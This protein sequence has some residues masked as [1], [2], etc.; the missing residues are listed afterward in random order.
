MKLG[1]YSISATVEI[2]ISL[3]LTRYQFIPAIEAEPP[4]PAPGLKNGL[5]AVYEANETGGTTV[6]D[7]TGYGRN[8]TA[9][10]PITTT[11][12]GKV[13][14][15]SFAWTGTN[16]TAQ[17]TDPAF[18][19]GNQ[20]TIAKLVKLGNTSGNQTF[21]GVGTNGLV[22][23]EPWRLRKD[24]SANR[25]QFQIRG[26]GTTVV[27]G[28]TAQGSLV[29]NTS[30][31]VLLIGG[32]NRD[33]G[34]VWLSENGGPKVVTNVTPADY[35]P[36][37]QDYTTF[38]IGS[39]NG[40]DWGR[41]LEDETLIW[42]RELSDA[43]IA[44]YWNG[45]DVLSYAEFDGYLGDY[46]V[47]PPPP[48]PD[49]EWTITNRVIHRNGT[50]FFPLGMYYLDYTLTVSQAQAK[51]AQM[52][53]IGCNCAVITLSLAQT[54]VLDTAASLGIFV[55]VE[56][57]D[58]AGSV[59][60]AQALNSREEYAG[61]MVFDDVNNYTRA[62]LQAEHAALK[63]VAP[64]KLTMG[65]G[66]FQLGDRILD[67]DVPAIQIYPISI[68]AAEEPGESM[69]AM[70]ASYRNATFA[71]SVSNNVPLVFNLQ[72]YKAGTRWPTEN[73]LRNMFWQ[74]M[75]FGAS[76]V[77]TYSAWGNDTPEEDF[78]GESGLVDE[79]AAL[80][81]EVLGRQV[82]F[83]NN[84]RVNGTT[85]SNYSSIGY[86][87]SPTHYLVVA[88]NA[89]DTSDPENTAIDGLSVSIT[90]PA[91]ATGTM[92][93]LDPRYGPTLNRTGTTISATLNAEQVTAYLIERA[94]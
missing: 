61:P 23:A 82:M 28:R 13:G 15:T 84:S 73:E 53:D 12:D 46:P 87:T 21:A 17:I 76:G 18:L 39:M 64:T 91:D 11:A 94:V 93:K 70:A 86:F 92:A 22:G 88:L 27:G 20:L 49:P 36:V 44:Q 59:A 79:L 42:N 34:T 71:A 77:I 58:G 4:P 90:L 14:S 3:A 89:S 26:G 1:E 25:Y 62:Q 37:R 5:I 54:A 50:P 69:I 45:G 32:Y 2:D 83:T 56:A 65:S 60:V 52:A 80:F 48:E 35:W 81:F 41:S 9:A 72:T 16:G 6:A 40:T 75:L 68:P 7:S 31:W 63:A 67:V 85:S 30:D 66:D 19:P 43:E 47:D 55:W 8:L 10:A 24:S 33:T 74:G 38:H 57:N 29:P 51:L 78:F